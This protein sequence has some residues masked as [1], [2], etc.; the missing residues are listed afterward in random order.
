MD[1]SNLLNNPQLNQISPEKLQFLLGLA[2][3]PQTSSTVDL[4]SSLMAASAA[5]K[6]KGVGFDPSEIELIVEVLKQN[7]SEADQKK[8]DLILS[9]M[10]AKNK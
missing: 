1:F 5:A 9:M 10:H 3:Q 8:A 2:N 6:N 4:A 7:L